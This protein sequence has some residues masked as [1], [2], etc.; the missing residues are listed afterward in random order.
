MINLITKVFQLLIHD[1][2]KE[3]SDY[4]IDKK[5][6]IWKI[7]KGDDITILHS[8]CVSDNFKL[9]GIPP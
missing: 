5:N 7:K 8:A 9:V 6:E 1:N 2:Q 4:I 3:L